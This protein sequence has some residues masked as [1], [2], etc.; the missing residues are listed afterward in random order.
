MSEIVSYCCT[1]PIDSDTHICQQCGEWG[2]PILLT[3]LME[4]AAN[5]IIKNKLL[6]AETEISEVW[7]K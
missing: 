3:E 4:K 6:K 1:A 7:K 5:I 2:E